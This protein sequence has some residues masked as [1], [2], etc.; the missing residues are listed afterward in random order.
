MEL[1][2]REDGCT[3]R[4]NTSNGS[5]DVWKSGTRGEGLFKKRHLKYLLLALTAQSAVTAAQETFTLNDGTHVSVDPTKVLNASDPNNLDTSN[6]SSKRSANPN[7]AAAKMLVARDCDP[8]SD[9]PYLCQSGNRCC[10]RDAMCCENR[11]CIDPD[12]HTCCLY[13]YYCNKPDRCVKRTDGS[14]GCLAP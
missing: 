5:A 3:A 11:S 10:R 9:Y 8:S 1:V 12:V 7:T 13:G 14:I 4:N 6:E 2:I